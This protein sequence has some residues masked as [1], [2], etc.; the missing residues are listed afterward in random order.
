VRV[1]L[2]SLL[3]TPPRNKP[4]D[5]RGNNTAERVSKNRS[6]VAAVESRSSGT[7]R[8]RPSTGP[9]GVVSGVD[10]LEG[11]G[12]AVKSRTPVRI[13]SQST[14][15]SATKAQLK[16]LNRSEASQQAVAMKGDTRVLKLRSKPLVRTNSGLLSEMSSVMGCCENNSSLV[17]LSMQSLLFEE[18]NNTFSSVISDVAGGGN[19]N[20]LLSTGLV[21]LWDE[22]QITG[23]PSLDDA[24][25]L[26]P[27]SLDEISTQIPWSKSSLVNISNASHVPVVV[28]EINPL[29]SQD[30][31]NMAR[32]LHDL[33]EESHVDQSLCTYDTAAYNLNSSIIALDRSIDTEINVNNLAFI[34]HDTSTTSVDGENDSYNT[35][36]FVYMK[37]INL[38]IDLSS[39]TAVTLELNELSDHG[40][41]DCKVVT[42][43]E[44]AD[45]PVART[46]ATGMKYPHP[47]GRYVFRPIV[48]DTVS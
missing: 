28:S 21:S 47:E 42:Q 38:F 39:S 43:R 12:T 27:C 3:T 48:E 13:P 14:S 24:S 20:S 31:L 6:A 15:H 7:S 25:F 22:L 41:A 44:E 30:S 18:T 36:R 23:M 26:S 45:D 32:F 10:P 40:W 46:L 33:E 8:P 29:S 35:Y 9:R 2:E 34:L 19:S 16:R 4:V 11:K 5:H 17:S 37:C 1:E